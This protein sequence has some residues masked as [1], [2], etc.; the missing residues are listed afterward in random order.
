M[1]IGLN[2]LQ[3]GFA[4]EVLR[5]NNLVNSSVPLPNRCSLPPGNILLQQ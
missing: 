5:T 1:H 4:I 3:V 2:L